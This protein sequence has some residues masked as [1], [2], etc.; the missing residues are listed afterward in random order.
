MGKK[1]NCSH[2]LWAVAIEGKHP[3]KRVEVVCGPT[4]S[5][6]ISVGPHRGDI[7]NISIILY[8]IINVWKQ[9]AIPLTVVQYITGV[10][11]LA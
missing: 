4:I 7:L 8:V 6:L 1:K 10:N 11:D 3:D 9:M 2:S 5:G